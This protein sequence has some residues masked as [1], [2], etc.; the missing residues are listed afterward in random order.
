MIAV[1]GNYFK[2]DLFFFFDGIMEVKI[3]R[4]IEGNRKYHWSLSRIVRKNN[5]RIILILKEGNIYDIEI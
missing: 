4:N 5:N 1:I 2:G 3:L